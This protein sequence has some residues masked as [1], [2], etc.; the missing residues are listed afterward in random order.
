MEGRI[1]AFRGSFRRKSG[2]QMIVLVE[3]VSDKAKA[4]ALVGKTV[5]W[6]APGKDKKQLKGKVSAAHGGKGAVRAIF[7]TGMPG[8]SLGS[9]VKIE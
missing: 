7:E 4:Q 8:Q 3:G 9:V 5:V 2:N 6:V 1:S